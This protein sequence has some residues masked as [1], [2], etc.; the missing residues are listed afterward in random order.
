MLIA[1]RNGMAVPTK[2]KNPYVTDGLVAMWDGEWNAGGGVHDA[3]ATTWRDIVRNIDCPFNAGTSTTPTWGNDYWSPIS[4]YQWFE[5][6]YPDL[7]GV[8]G[9]TIEFVLSKST[10]SRGVAIGSYN[11]SGGNSCNFE[12]F[13]NQFRA[14]YYSNPNLLSG[15]NTFPLNTRLSFSSIK[16]GT[17][18][19]IYANGAQS[20]YV[21]S[22]GTHFQKPSSPC[23]IGT[24]SRAESMIF[25]GEICNIR[26]YS[27]ALTTAEITSNYAVD[28]IRF[29]LP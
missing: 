1:R 7:S 9:H 24:D 10:G 2:W 4:Q 5:A 21:T 19:R 27:R 16:D 22:N 29:N 6:S 18:Y 26:I 25:Y 14:Y 13:S 12:F 11:L 28:K 8:T 23:R 15:T 17:T 3:E 20:T